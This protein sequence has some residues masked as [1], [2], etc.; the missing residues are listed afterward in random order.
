MNAPGQPGTALLGGAGDD[1]TLQVLSGILA[2]LVSLLGVALLVLMGGNPVG[3][4]GLCGGAVFLL[5][6]GR[7][8]ALGVYILLGASLL[9]EQ[10]QIF[11]LENLVALKIPFWLNLNL[12]TGVGALMMNSVELLLGLMVGLWFLR[13]MTSRQWE[14]SPIPNLGVA[15]VFL[16]MLLFFTAYGLATGGD[17]KV[18]LW[19]IRALYYLCAMYFITP[20]LIRTRRQVVVCVWI[21]ILGVNVKG[22]QGCWR[23]FVDL[24]GSMGDIPAITGHEDALFMSTTFILTLAF[25]LLDYHKKQ[26]WALLAFF[27]FTFL[28]FLVTQR[29][30]AYGVFAFSAIIVFALI[31]RAKQILAL[32]VCAPLVPLMLV[33]AVAFWNSHSTLGLPVQQVK[34]I[35]VEGE[36][37]DSSNTYRKVEDFNLEQTIRTFPQGIGFGKKYLV[38]LPLDE[39]DFPLWDYIPHNCIYWIWAKTGCV[40]FT[41]FWLFFGISVAQAVIQFRKTDD[42]YFQAIYLMVITFIISQI[43]VAKYDLQ[44]TFYRNMIY[45]G[46]CMGMAAAMN[47]ILQR[48][49]E[50]EEKKRLTG[51]VGQES[52]TLGGK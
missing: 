29:R 33:Y 46:T 21:I 10:F 13:A 28:T 23:F 7:H 38:I 8:L 52:G 11:G 44:I 31:P 43:I 2:V 50:N 15:V 19:E 27:P 20:Q 51:E 9:L 6:L 42:K 4:A 41:I 34:S 32:K 45:L 47:G 37:E 30:I 35:F 49:R 25:F 1:R 24:G 39:V 12:I 17:L 40:G 16:G 36:E 48:E 26:F 14:L 5:L 22:L 18:A 3:V